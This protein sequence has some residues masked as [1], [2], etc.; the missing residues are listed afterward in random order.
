MQKNVRD[1]VPDI[2]C[3]I[4]RIL[5]DGETM[6]VYYRSGGIYEY[7]DISDDLVDNLAKAE[8]PAAFMV[9]HIMPDRQ[10]IPVVDGEA[11]PS[12]AWD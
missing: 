2:S 7:A 8:S 4:V 6:R 1:L 9:R 11:F 12:R 3:A 10:A 5:H